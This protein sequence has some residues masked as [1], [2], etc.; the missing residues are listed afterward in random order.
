M[1]NRKEKEEEA[2]SICLAKREGEE[3]GKQESDVCGL[4]QRRGWSLLSKT[5]RRR[6]EEEEHDEETKRETHKKKSMH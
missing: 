1:K 5:T 6:E 4:V 2:L 3:G